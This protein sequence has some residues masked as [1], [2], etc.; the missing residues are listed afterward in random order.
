MSNDYL[1][2]PKPDKRW[3]REKRIAWID[4]NVGKPGL[5]AGTHLLCK[6]CERPFRIWYSL[7]KLIG[8]H[9]S[10]GDTGEPTDWAIRQLCDLCDDKWYSKQWKKN[11]GEST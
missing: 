2:R 4:E 11:Q 3:S 5:E 10:G 9:G 8:K 7:T 6:G 1:K